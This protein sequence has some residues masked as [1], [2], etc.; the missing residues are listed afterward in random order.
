MSS[1]VLLVLAQ[2]AAPAPVSAEQAMDTYRQ[3]FNA[4]PARRCAVS[5]DPNELVVCGRRAGADRLPLPVERE[6]GEPVRLLP[7]ESPRAS[8]PN[9]TFT[10]HPAF[11]I[12]LKMIGKAVESVKRA[13]ED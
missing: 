5:D 6:S 7:G 10:C 1:W 3:T 2:A 12:N 11:G 13:L 4:V 8:V 9:C